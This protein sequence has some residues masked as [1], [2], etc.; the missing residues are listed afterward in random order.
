M[1][2]LVL[3]GPSMTPS[4]DWLLTPCIMGLGSACAC[5][6]GGQ[7]QDSLPNGHNS[8]C[9]SN[10]ARQAFHSPDIP[11]SRAPL[12]QPITAPTDHS[13]WTITWSRPAV[14]YLAPSLHHQT[15]LLSGCLSTGM[16]RL[17]WSWGQGQRRV[18]GMVSVE[19]IAPGHPPEK[20]T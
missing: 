1:G 7:Y 5:A 10:S 3:C 12:V 15:V 13:C 19:P 16:R 20:A 14:C 6:E 2:W 17:P 18:H 8:T 11:A 9:P 4:M